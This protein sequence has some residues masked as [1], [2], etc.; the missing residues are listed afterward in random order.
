MRRLLALA[1]L[2]FAACHGGPASLG[3]EL[4]GGRQLLQTEKYGLVLKAV[5]GWI[6]LADERGDRP[7]QLRFRLMKAEALL[8][9]ETSAK[10]VLALL[11]GPGAVPPGPEWAADRAQWFILRSRALHLLGSDDELPSLLDRA[12]A[13]ALQANRPDLA[14][15]VELRRGNLFRYQGR[16]ADA[17]DVYDHALAE[18]RR[19]RDPYL[20]A[21]TED[22]I[23]LLLQSESRHDEAIPVLQSS[24]SVAREIGAADTAARA[25]GNLGIS[26]FRLG[27][28][29]NARACFDTA[30]AEFTLAG[31]PFEVQIWIGNAGNVYY[32]AGDLQTA[33][34]SYRRALG[35][36]RQVDAPQWTGRWLSNLASIA[37]E[38]ADWD[39]AAK[40]NTDALA[41]KAKTNDA[42]YQASS[43]VNAGRIAAGRGDPVQARTLFESALHKDSEDPTVVLDAHAGLAGLFARR[44]AVGD[45]ESEFRNTLAEIDRRQSALIGDDYRLSWLGS[46]VSFYQQYVDFLI[47][48]GQPERALEA[49]ESSRSKVLSGQPIPPL[50]ATGY[51]QLARQTGATLLEYWLGP[52]RSYLW[53][54]TPDR[55]VCHDLPPRAEI[56]PLIRRYRAV[57]SGGRNPLDVA[58]DIGRRLFN[59]LLAPAVADAASATQFIVVPDGELDSLNLETLPDG[60]NANRFWIDRATVRISPSL[61]YLAVNARRAPFGANRK[62]LIIGDPVTS[63]PQYPHLEFAGREISA[64]ADAMQANQALVIRGA[65]ATPESYANAMPA[66]FGFIHFSAHAA[67]AAKRESALDSA[68][69]LSGP[70][71]KC[72]LVARDV[73]AIP[74]NAELVTVSAC[75]GAGGRS[76]GGEGLV[77]FSWAFMKAGAGNVIAG[78]W[79][80][81]DRSTLLLMSDLYRH[82]A[83]GAPVAEALRSSKLALIHGGGSYAKP[84]YWAPFQLY[85]AR[86]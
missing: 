80:V 65:A 12:G 19:L 42:E 1:A 15:E 9:N 34:N 62:L 75:R 79:D 40:Y 68:V 64:I 82:I 20:E 55:V 31:N 73:L 39:S 72:R 14:E 29:D 57:V 10:E 56:L 3:S 6:R 69:I 41:L 8:G 58:D 71:D 84:F 38:R 63:L 83:A 70:P 32:A 61:N 44:G 2:I 17:R 51:R 28:Y 46:L 48:Q 67:A 26:Y 47:A 54:V 45:A 13:A 86:P 22:S 11:T 21:R 52:L 37:I 78:L 5:D 66:N 53:V 4:A 16:F 81:N 18:S 30:E 49:A 27:D 36:S 59:V 50:A 35:I 76:Y 7:A 60:A 23:G 25:E 77:G 33:A 43:L 24:R 74:L 85:T